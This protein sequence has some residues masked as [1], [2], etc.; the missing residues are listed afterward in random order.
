MGPDDYLDDEE[1]QRWSFRSILASGWFR[2][3][4]L[5]GGIVIA[6][7]LTL[8]Y[9]LRWM[10]PSD[11]RSAQ[12]ARRL[13]EPP[14]PAPAPAPSTVTTPPAPSVA[15]AGAPVVAGA[16]RPA[17]ADK[18][19]DTPA[20]VT[21]RSTP[22]TDRIV[23]AADKPRAA[24]ALASTTSKVE[25]TDKTARATDKSATPRE[26][27]APPAARTQPVAV[28]PA[29]ATPAAKPASTVRTAVARPSSGGDF[30][31]Q[32]GAF[33][34]AENAQ[35]LQKTLRGS[36]MPAAVTQVA[37]ETPAP[38]SRHEVFVTGATPEAVN[39]ALRG[40]GTARAVKGGVAVQP[41]LELKDAVSVSKRLTADGL[42]VKIR[43]VGGDAADADGRPQHVVRVGPYGSRSEA[44]EARRDLVGKGLAGFVAQGPAR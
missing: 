39:A 35:R 42:A 33:Q 21:E 25:A 34:D 14:R 5:L 43:R 13:V 15:T 29:P 3:G 17:A 32:V 44:T 16:D 18:P 36:G 9:A 26:A 30:W 41:A 7:V 20:P 6:L 1:E 23:P 38:S 12:Q 19:R 2:A 27:A 31:V 24:D 40:G 4:L 11:T 22:S 8:P 10:S 28:T 37:R